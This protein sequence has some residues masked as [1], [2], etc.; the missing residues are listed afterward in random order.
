[1]ANRSAATIF[2]YDVDDL[3]DMSVDELV[4]TEHRRVHADRRLSFARQPSRRPMGT[5]LQLFGQHRDGDTFP[6]EIS[7]SPITL[8]GEVQTIAAVRDVSE[9]QEA[10][11]R[12]A[13]S[14]DRERIAHD[15]HDLVIQR[16]FAAGMSLQSVIGLVESSVARDRII[17]VT[18]E[19]DETVRAL[20]TAIFHLGRTDTHQS[21][22]AHLAELIDERSRHLG[23]T[24]DVNIVG[25]ID[26]LPEFIADQLIATLTEALSNVVRHA[27]ATDASVLVTRLDGELRLEVSD[28]GAGISAAPKPLGGLSNMMWRAAELGGACTVAPSGASGTRLVWYVPA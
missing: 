24:P 8:D 9:R 21:L 6:V 19:L 13:L 3:V 17:S 5:D 25:Q 18:D 12:L 10:Q 28:N 11:A 23:F 27:N 22:T 2:G 1:M 14:A 20:R 15:L 4:P 16:L 7:L 26:D